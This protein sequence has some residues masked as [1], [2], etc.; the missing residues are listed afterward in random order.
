MSPNP[1]GTETPL[2]Y[3]WTHI[4]VC[5]KANN[6]HHPPWDCCSCRTVLNSQPRRRSQSANLATFIPKGTPYSRSL[7]CASCKCV[8]GFVGG[9]SGDN[10]TGDGL[11][12]EVLNRKYGSGGMGAGE[13]V[14]G[15]SL[16]GPEGAL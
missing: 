7:A 4:D 10:P 16:I 9:S 3:A 5:Y 6:S 1:E 8:L 11:P 15:V 14:L 13:S 12:V 2:S